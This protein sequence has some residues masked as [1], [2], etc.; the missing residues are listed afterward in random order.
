MKKLVIYAADT[1]VAKK[2]LFGTS[3]TES[4]GLELNKEV[5][6]FESLSYLKSK[7]LKAYVTEIDGLESKEVPDYIGGYDYEINITPYAEAGETKTRCIQLSGDFDEDDFESLL[8]IPEILSILEHDS[9][10]SKL[11]DQVGAMS[12][13]HEIVLNYLVGEYGFR[14]NKF[15]YY[16]KSNKEGQED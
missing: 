1:N 5:D 3:L 4:V 14:V 11:V 9:K 8:R 15:Y 13:D 16:G 7:G 6:T 12:Y 2:I 10:F